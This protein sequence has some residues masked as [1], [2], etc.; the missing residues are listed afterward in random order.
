MSTEMLAG[1]CRRVFRWVEKDN[2]IAKE[3]GLMSC[4]VGKLNPG[5][6]S[7]VKRYIKCTSILLQPLNYPNQQ[8]SNH[9]PFYTHLQDTYLPFSPP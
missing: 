1:L 7:M 5:P 6:R 8:F 9:L 2:N 4:T 3:M